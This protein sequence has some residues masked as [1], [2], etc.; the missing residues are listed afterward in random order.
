[1]RPTSRHGRRTNDSARSARAPRDLP[2]ELTALVGRA[3]ELTLL[4]EA[5]A[6]SRLVTVVGPGGIGKS[7]LVARAAATCALPDGARLVD[8]APLAAGELVEYA[9]AQALGLTEHAVRPAR[10]VLVDHFAPQRAL[11]VLDGFEHLVDGC[12]GLVRTLL[13]AAPGLRVLAA[14]RRPLG[15]RGERVVPLAPLA[16]GDAVALF[17]DRAGA[18]LPGFALDEANAA[19]VREICRRLDGIPLAVELAAGRLTA[20]SPGQLLHRLDDR[21]RLL[22]GGGRD[23]LPRHRT[24]RTAIGWSHELC[25]TQERLLWAR[26]S[27]FSGTFDLEAAEYVCG[28]DGLPPDEVLDVLSALLDQS[29]VH[30]EDGPSGARYRMLETVRAYGADWLE[31]S[32]DTARLRRRHLDWYAGLAAWCELEWFSPRQ[33]EVAARTAAELP[34]VRAALEHALTEPGSTPV[35]LHVAGTLWFCWVG[36]GRLAEGRHW[37]QRG[38]ELDCGPEGACESPPDVRLKA[39]WVLGHVAALQGDTVAALAALHECREEAERTDDALAVAHAE[40]RTGVLALVADDAERAERLLRSALDHYREIGELNSNVLMARVELATAL[41][42][43]H[44]PLAGGLG[45][46]D[47]GRNAVAEAVG[48]CEEVREACEDHGERWAL[49]Y[50]LLVLAYAAWSEGDPARARRLLEEGLVIG[51]A[52]GDLLGVALAVELLALVTLDEGDPGEAAVLQGAA[53]GL[54][55]SAGRHSLGPASPRAARAPRALGERRARAALGDARY[56]EGLRRGAPLGLDAAVRRALGR[57]AGPV[58]A[59]PECPREAAD[60]RT[61]GP[62]APPAPWSGEATGPGA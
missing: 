33:R 26:L 2:L 14:G 32:G 58:P 12:A 1:M 22:T 17:A 49:S 6:H 31:G 46:A 16:E 10:A 43:Q 28:G 59:P 45:D 23:A 38:L 51:H 44:D 18:V 52:F 60:A 4:G 53:G 57:G 37:L 39:L 55:P 15:V 48:W 5:T 54:W 20:L 40:H 3:P 41:I 29:V 24:L 56:E 21:F 19:D 50:A 8:L 9:V 13:R 35:A 27:V 36:C 47:G 62:V 30:R 42:F 11:L 61:P 34:N 25:T 7:R